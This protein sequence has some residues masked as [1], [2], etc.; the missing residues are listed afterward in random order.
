MENIQ[1]DSNYGSG[2]E[3]G[4]KWKERGEREAWGQEMFGSCKAKRSHLIGQTN[5]GGI[6]QVTYCLLFNIN[7][8]LYHHFKCVSKLHCSVTQVE[9]CFENTGWED[10]WHVSYKQRH[11]SS[12]STIKS[13]FLTPLNKCWT[14]SKGIL[15]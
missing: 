14:N 1:T 2:A 13:A 3:S 10:S 12:F 6:F 4:G 7:T 11:N 9:F 8:F 5:L 15:V